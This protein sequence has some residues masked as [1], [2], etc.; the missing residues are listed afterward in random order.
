MDT[1][2]TITATFATTDAGCNNLASGTATITAAAGVAPYTF[3]WDTLAASQTTATATG[4]AAGAYTVMIM[5]STGCPGTA[6]VTIDTTTVLPTA[7]IGIASNY[8]GSDIS[9]NGAADGVATAAPSLGATPYTYLWSANAQTTVTA[10]GLAAGTHTVTVTDA[11]TC[12]TTASITLTEPTAITGGAS[13]TTSACLNPTGTAT[14]TPAGGTAPYSYLWDTAAVNQTTATATGLGQGVYMV[15]FSDVNNCSSIRM[16]T[17]ANGNAPTVS[18]TVISNYNG[19][20]VSCNGASDATASVLAAGGQG[21]YTYNWSTVGQVADTAVGLAAGIYT[22]TVT[23]SL[24]CANTASVTITEPTALSLVDSINNVACF[25]DSTGLVSVNVSGGTGAYTYNWSNNV[26]TATNANLGAGVYGFT[27]TDVNACTTVRNY[28]LTE[29]TALTMTNAT[30][31]VACF[32]DSTGL[33][34]LAVSGGTGVYTYNWSNNTATAANA[35]LAAGTYT[36][37]VSDVNNCILTESYTITEGTAFVITPSIINVACFGDS[38]GTIGVA[39]SG[40]VAGY[41]YAWSN[42]V[43]TASNANVAA[44]S[45][46]LV[47]TDSIGCTASTSVV[48]AQPTALSVALTTTNDTITAVVSGGTG[49]VSA[50]WS[51]GDSSFVITPT[52]GGTFTLV[53]TD[54]NGCT[55]S[56]SA[57]IT[58]SNVASTFASNEVNVY[59]NPASVSATV[60]LNLATAKDVSI[61]VVNALGQVVE[62]VEFEQVAQRELV[63]NTNNYAAGIYMINIK[64]GNALMT[65]RLVVTR[66]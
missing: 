65:K 50:A 45:Y 62:S 53:A 21:S 1:C 64:A 40:G 61:V 36:V 3:V 13:S 46:N 5:D 25:G 63:L 11:Q 47:V 18:A 49:V 42:N 66:Q 37:T 7:T 9:C 19:S 34:S 8:N 39:V 24:S 44:G 33:V 16:V 38:T 35:N 27:V 56:D 15:T 59:P 26:A 10:T 6:S 17:V 58:L 55:V 31:N 14:I 4:L 60:A 29:P 12:V 51:N 2:A 22:V 28:T 43:T 23:D 48:V 20:D 57:T 54:A 32:G 41:T 52:T 30:T